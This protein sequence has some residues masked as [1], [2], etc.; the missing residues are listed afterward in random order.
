[1]VNCKMRLFNHTTGI[2]LIAN[3]EWFAKHSFTAYNCKHINGVNGRLLELDCQDDLFIFLKWDAK[4]PSSTN[5]LGPQQVRTENWNA[6]HRWCVYEKWLWDWRTQFVYDPFPT[7]HQEGNTLP[8]SWKLKGQVVTIG[9]KSLRK[10]YLQPLKNWRRD[11][12]ANGIFICRRGL[13][14]ACLDCSDLVIAAAW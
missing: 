6:F 7:L 8:R 14:Y 4:D 13:W 5:I 11:S 2:I 12:E 3:S 10:M 1:M 9:N